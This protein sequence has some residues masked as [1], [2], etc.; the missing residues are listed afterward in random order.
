MESKEYLE[1]TQEN[2]EEG[3]YEIEINFIQS[4]YN[5]HVANRYINENI[6]DDII[7]LYGN[8]NFDT[9]KIDEHDVKILNIFKNKKK[10]KTIINVEF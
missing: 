3:S 4:K 10:K 6:L 1:F 8:G 7:I 5:S 9:M 2:K